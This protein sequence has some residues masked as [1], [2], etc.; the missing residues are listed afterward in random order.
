MTRQRRFQVKLPPNKG[1]QQT[2]LH[3]AADASR[4]ALIERN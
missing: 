4:W 3:A 1:M 2:A